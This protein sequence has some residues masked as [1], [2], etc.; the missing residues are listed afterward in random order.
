MEKRHKLDG[1][2]PT[3]AWR[4]LMAMLDAEISGRMQ[5]DSY[6][7]LLNVHRPSLSSF[8][9]ESVREALA[10]MKEH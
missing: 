5:L 3:P 7:M 8:T 4:F 6:L 1:N 10:Q 2:P 9:L